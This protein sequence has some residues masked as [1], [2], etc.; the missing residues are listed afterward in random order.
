MIY[1]EDIDTGKSLELLMIE[2]RMQEKQICVFLGISKESFQLMES[3]KCNNATPI[4]KL[5]VAL[6][7]LGVEIPL[8]L[9]S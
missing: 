7:D 4:H 3:N 1:K 2:K 5:V 6:K 8:N 9:E